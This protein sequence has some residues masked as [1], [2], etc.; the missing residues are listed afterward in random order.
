MKLLIQSLLLLIA[1]SAIA[2]DFPD[3]WRKAT[4]EELESWPYTREGSKSKYT[5]AHADFNGDGK[6]DSAYLLKSTR[7][8]GQGLLVKL[9]SGNSYT[10]IE[11][12]VINWDKLYPDEDF[13]N[14]SLSMGISVL[15][16]KD[17]KKY[18]K[19]SNIETSSDD[20]KPEDY[21]NPAI[22]YFAF[23]SAGS[24]IYWSQSENQFKRY[25]YSD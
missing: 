13:G 2:Y 20:L 7:F 16:P 22:R 21:Q 3:G 9:S 12:H 19:E 11:V 8:S 17:V 10:W 4:P 1:T 23:G 18:I 15:S 14:V 5:E 24:I 25:W 6:I